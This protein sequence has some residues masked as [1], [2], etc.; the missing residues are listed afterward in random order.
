[1]KRLL[2][3]ATAAAILLMA[4]CVE[5]SGP[6]AE[7]CAEPS[8]TIDV[9]LTA[10]AMEPSAI[11]VCRDQNVTLVT[12][13]DVD[14]VIHIHGYDDQIPATQLEADGETHLDFTASRSG[15]FPVE[16]HPEADPAGIE[17]GVFTVHE[18]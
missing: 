5:D 6:D 4:G 11:S 2:L 7:L 12:A 9:S 15:Q 1:M 16:L 8:V 14:G 18:P 17:V 10:E 13:S 3:A